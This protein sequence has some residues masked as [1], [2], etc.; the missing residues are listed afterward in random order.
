ME[1]NLTELATNARLNH[2]PPHL[3]V[4]TEAEKVTYLA[5]ALEEADRERVDYDEVH[6][7]MQ[8]EIDSLREKAMDLET[9]I[10]SLK[11]DLEALE[12]KLEDEK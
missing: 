3:G 6:A 5:N 1:I 4:R 12:E 2:W 10:Q 11:D 7:E 9:Q 8:S